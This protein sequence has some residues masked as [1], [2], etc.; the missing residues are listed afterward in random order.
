ML[1]TKRDQTI[2]VTVNMVNANIA[3]CLN[4]LF[5]SIGFNTILSGD[6]A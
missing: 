6:V 5:F 2:Y 3:A 1:N 4:E